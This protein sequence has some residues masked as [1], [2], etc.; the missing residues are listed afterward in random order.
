MG[1]L[2]AAMVV[3]G[4]SLCSLGACANEVSPPGSVEGTVESAESA[5]PIGTK[6]PT[7][8]I[9]KLPRPPRPPRPP[10]CPSPAPQCS[11]EALGW[12]P[13]DQTFRALGCGDPLHYFNGHNQGILGGIV[14]LCPDTPAVRAQYGFAVDTTCDAC[15]HACPGYFYAFLEEFIGPGCTHGCG[16]GVR[17]SDETPAD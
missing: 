3:A 17:A 15:L 8:P 6:D 9:E 16:Y 4:M 5:L 10:V 2:Y 12:E 14:T 13:A 11:A 1:K 7:P